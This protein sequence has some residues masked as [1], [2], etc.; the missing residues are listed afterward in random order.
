VYHAS[1][2]IK[3]KAQTDTRTN[4]ARFTSIFWSF[5]KIGAFTFGG[6]WAM[7]P[8]IRRELVERRRW[9]EDGEF[10]DLLA[11]A[12]SGPGPIAVNT[13]TVTG[14]KIRGKVGAVAAVLGA[15][16]P[17]F[18]VILAFASVLVRYKNAPA[19]DA[20]FRGM[21]PAILGL[22]V[23][24]VWQV[25]KNSVKRATDLWYVLAGAVLLF[26]LRQGPVTAVFTAGLMGVVAGYIERRTAAVKAKGQD[27]TTEGG[28]ASARTQGQNPAAV[29][30]KSLAGDRDT[31]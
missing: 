18:L 23:A 31:D 5:F 20:V 14:Y 15:A 17:S 22:L 10:V 19:I 8:L 26:V 21:R 11:I 30:Q 2:A 13:A 24:A 28:S 27:S 6:G 29:N 7:I 12:Q 3:T 25:G 9:L 1:G 4:E 16:M